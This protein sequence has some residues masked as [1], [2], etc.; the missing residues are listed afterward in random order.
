MFRH[1]PHAFACLA[2]VALTACA[3]EPE[4]PFDHAAY[5]GI[6]TIGVLQPAMSPS[7]TIWLASDV[8]QSFGLIGALVDASMQAN[9]DKRFSEL[10]NAQGV[11]PDAIFLADIHTTLTAHGYSVT[12]VPE[13]RPSMDLLKTYPK[14][15]ADGVDAYLDIAIVNYGYV[16]AGIGDSTP[17]RPFVGAHCRLVRASDGAVLMQDMVV[18]NP[19]VTAGP[20]QRAVTISPDPAYTFKDFDTLTGDPPNAM[21]G[22]NVGLG[23]TANSIGTLVQ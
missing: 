14:G 18:Y 11:K 23:D 16:A 6:K 7:P 5:P 9:R 8:G 12:D 13:A 22:M 17:Y 19:V 2:L 3:T 4:I 20:Q 21:K 1:I 15:G 10:M